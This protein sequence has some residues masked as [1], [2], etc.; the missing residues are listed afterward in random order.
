MRLSHLFFILGLSRIFVANRMGGKPSDF[1]TQPG[2]WRKAVVPIEYSFRIEPMANSLSLTAPETV[3]VNVR[4][5]VRQIVLNALELEI[6]NASVDNEPLPKSAIKIDRK[7]ELLT[8]ALASEL[9][10][11]EHIL[12]L[13]FAGKINQQGQGLF[14]VRYQEQ[15]TA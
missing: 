4:T 7:N 6:T 10:A 11:G 1:A 9:P 13:G 15:G 3:K 2:K 12:A 8:L 5:P 14:Y